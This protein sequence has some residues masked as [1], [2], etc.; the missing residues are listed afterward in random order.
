MGA[1]HFCFNVWHFAPH[2]R[3]CL[4][5]LVV[6]LS[7]LEAGIFVGRNVCL[8]GAFG[9]RR[10]LHFAWNFVQNCCVGFAVSGN[11]MNSFGSRNFRQRVDWAEVLAEAS[12]IAIVL[13]TATGFLVLRK[14]FWKTICTAALAKEKVCYY[15]EE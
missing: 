10:G 4:L 8:R 6:W 3:Q 5:G 13:C 11:Q 9:C 14:A 2:Q 12:I 15:F 1:R 7:L